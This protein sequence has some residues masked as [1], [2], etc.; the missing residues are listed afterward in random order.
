MY[1]IRHRG[2]YGIREFLIDY[3]MCI[4][5]VLLRCCGGDGRLQGDHVSTLNIQARPNKVRCDGRVLH[6]WSQ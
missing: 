6:T 5:L 4:N 1:R 3:F 2:T